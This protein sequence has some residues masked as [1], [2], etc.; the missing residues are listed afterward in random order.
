[1]R[2]SSPSSTNWRARVSFLWVRT[3]GV[4]AVSVMFAPVRPLSYDRVSTAVAMAISSWGPDEGT[5]RQQV[6]AEQ[7]EGDEDERGPAEPL[8]PG[9]GAGRDG[10][11]EAQA[12]QRQATAGQGEGQG[13]QGG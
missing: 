9:S 6:L 12:D 4:R 1:M 11:A 10:G 8:R 5:S 3:S 2:G 13:R 7:G